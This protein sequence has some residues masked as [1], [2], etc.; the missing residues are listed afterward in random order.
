[1]GHGTCTPTISASL[2]LSLELCVLLLELESYILELLV[3]CPLLI[4]PH[5]RKG[6]CIFLDLVIKVVWWGSPSLV[7]AFDVSLKG[8]CHKTFSR[9]V[10]V[11]V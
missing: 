7:D 9:G 11:D 6:P 1:M 2:D 10:I 4:H 5:A 3:S 8:I